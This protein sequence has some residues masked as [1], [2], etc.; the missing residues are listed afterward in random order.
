MNRL[1]SRSQLQELLSKWEAGQLNAAAVHDWAQKRYAAS[2]FEP[3]DRVVNEVL[4][5]LDRLDLDLVTVEDVPALEE[6]LGAS[7]ES[8]EKAL[9]LYEAYWSRINLDRRRIQ[10]ASDPLYARF[11]VNGRVDR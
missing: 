7:S 9:A 11:C 6:L 1:L 5:R 4:A 3:E 2:L 10:L 8:L